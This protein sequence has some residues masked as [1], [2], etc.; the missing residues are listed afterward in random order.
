MKEYPGAVEIFKLVSLCKLFFVCFSLFCSGEMA[1]FVKLF[2]P[3]FVCVDV[4]MNTSGWSNAILNKNAPQ[5]H[6]FWNNIQH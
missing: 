6:S 4:L 5:L 1:N 3:L 2:G